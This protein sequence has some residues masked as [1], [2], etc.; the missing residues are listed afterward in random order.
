MTPPTAPA[1]NYVAEPNP[2]PARRAALIRE[3]AEFPGKLAALVANLNDTQLDTKYR[4]WT[5]RQIVYHLG[6]SHIH[7][8]AR[9]HLALT[10]E[11]PTVKPYDETRTAELPES[12]NAD[13]AQA[14]DTLTV[15]H[16]RWVTCLK[17]M[18]S[19]QFE[20]TYVHPQYQ[21]MSSLA[22]VL[23]L[24]AHH[25]RHHAGQIEWLIRQNGW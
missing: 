12:R 3:I 13:I 22:E 17:A 10:E 21:K 20:R 8:Y 11:N 19:E 4:N 15:I 6:E 5:I 24:Y 25:G 1:G 16:R 23:G 9:F 14:L 18:T 7:A 2:S